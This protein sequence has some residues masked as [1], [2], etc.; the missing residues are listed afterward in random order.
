VVKADVPRLSQSE[1]QD[2]H[3]HLMSCWNPPPSVA[4]PVTVH[5][6]LNP[7]CSISGEPKVADD[8]NTAFFQISADSALKAVR[9]CQ[10]FRLP[11]PKYQAWREL[12]VKFDPKYVV[13]G[14]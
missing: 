5:F 14:K 8:G 6:S 3:T 1:I 2:L 9:S 12:E 4:E 11:A 7:D 13:R 10:P